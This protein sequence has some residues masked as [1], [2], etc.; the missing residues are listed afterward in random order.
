MR[1]GVYVAGV[2]GLCALCTKDFVGLGRYVLAAFPCFAA[3]GEL[4]A[5]RPRARWAVLGV[6]GALLLFVTHLHARNMLIS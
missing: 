4:L 6:S 1:Y 2:V 5:E 3:A